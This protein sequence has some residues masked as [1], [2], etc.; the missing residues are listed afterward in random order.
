VHTTEARDPDNDMGNIANLIFP[1]AKETYCY[2]ELY[3][4]DDSTTAKPNIIFV[5]DSYT[6]NLIRT[7]VINHMGSTWQFWFY[8]D[9]IFNKDDNYGM[10]MKIASYDWEGELKKADC[11]IILHTPR[12]TD[13]IGSGF[14]E[15]AYKYYFP[16]K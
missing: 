16:G 1:V 10:N 11:I 5:G 8:F 9:R 7:G 13:N 2:P 12:Q 4:P 15:A 6:V 14:V 3:Y